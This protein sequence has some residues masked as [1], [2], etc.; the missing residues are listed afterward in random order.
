MFCLKNKKPPTKVEGFKNIIFFYFYVC[1]GVG[2]G[3]SVGVTLGV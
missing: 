1:E 3:V 2:V